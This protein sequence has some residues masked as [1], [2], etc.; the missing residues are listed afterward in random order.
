M[1]YAQLL[2]D[3][4]TSPSVKL[5]KSDNAAFTISFLYQEYKKDVQGRR[6]DTIPYQTLVQHLETYLEN[7]NAADPDSYPRRPSE[8]MRD[9]LDSGYI[10]EYTDTRSREKVVELTAHAER[11]I[12]W[13]EDLRQRF[14]VGTESRLL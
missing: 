2:Q 1:D 9:W 14:F 13:L 12:G 7:L 10:R 5:I 8:Y 11:A 4:R 3:L 6:N